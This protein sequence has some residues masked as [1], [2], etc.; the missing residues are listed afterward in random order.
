MRLAASNPLSTG[1]PTSI[2]MKCGRHNLKVSTALAPSSA[3]RTENPAVWQG[4]S[5]ERPF[6]GLFSDNKD[7]VGGRAGPKARHFQGG[8]P[9]HNLRRLRRL[10]GYFYTE[11]RA[12]PGGALH[13]ND[14]AQELND[15]PAN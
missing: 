5:K 10:C 13:L 3:T 1:R 7:R 12:T 4:A 9:G 15:A 11:P 14:S 6:P 8:V 2:Q